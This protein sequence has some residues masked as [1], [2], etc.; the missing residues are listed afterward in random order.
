[1]SALNLNTEETLV[2]TAMDT[3][4]EDTFASGVV[5]PGG[6]PATIPMVYGY[7]LL[8]TDDP[9]TGNQK[10]L[11][12]NAF[13]GPF[14]AFVSALKSAFAYTTATDYGTGWSAWGDGTYSAGVVRYYKNIFGEV[15]VQGLARAPLAPGADTTILTLP[16]GYRPASGDAQ[17][18][19]CAHN[20]A[21]ACIQ[22][23]S[24]GRILFNGTPTADGW[25]SLNLSFKAG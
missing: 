8:K 6:T 4:L 12:K 3:P 11:T 20:S 13:R 2:I 9:R 18:V 5:L 19:A 22:V 10:E 21:F 1:M 7:T 14:A 23:F 15:R 16:A 17:I 24:D 25:V